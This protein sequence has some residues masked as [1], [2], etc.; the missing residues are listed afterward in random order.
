V[1]DLGFEARFV[2]VKPSNPEAFEARLKEGGMGSEKLERIR[3]SLAEEAQQ[4][5]PP[6]GFY[7][8]TIPNDDLE[9]TCKALEAFIYGPTPN[10]EQAN[11]E[12]SADKNKGLQTEVAPNK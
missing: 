3:N 9:N 2:H 5:S 7:D 10:G 12:T 1:K 6:D 11:G 4:P 8:V